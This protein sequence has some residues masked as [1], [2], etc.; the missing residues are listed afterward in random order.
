[1]EW[2]AN[3]SPVGY[4]DVWFDINSGTVRGRDSDGPPA[5]SVPHFQSTS[6]IVRLAA[7]DTVQAYVEHLQ[8]GNQTLQSARLAIQK[9]A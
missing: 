9:I 8:G 5:A 2:P 4:R 6:A 1:M 3:G 7:A